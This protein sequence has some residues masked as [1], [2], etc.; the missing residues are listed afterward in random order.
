M[1]ELN[2]PGK[3]HK[4]AFDCFVFHRLFPI[5]M[6]RKYPIRI[7]RYI[8]FP[9]QNLSKELSSFNGTPQAVLGNPE[10]MEVFLPLLRSDIRYYALLQVS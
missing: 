4:H 9:M 6:R 1:V 7:L 2:A 10:L 8:T 3:I 5:D